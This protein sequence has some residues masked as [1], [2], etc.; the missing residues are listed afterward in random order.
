VGVTEWY[1]DVEKRIFIKE[2]E[3]G[4]ACS[5]RERD[6]KCIQSFSE[7]LGRR[8]IWKEFY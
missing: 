7:I 2:D 1:L 3:M 5:E 4:G 6:E 8:N